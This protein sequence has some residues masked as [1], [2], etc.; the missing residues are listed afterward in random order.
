MIE[1]LQS[2][3][4]DVDDS[5]DEEH[6]WLRSEHWNIDNSEDSVYSET[7]SDSDGVEC[8]YFCSIRKFSVD[9]K[10]RTMKC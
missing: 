5:V 7:G 1:L 9:N 10:V 6:V 3:G 4:S 2:H 8:G